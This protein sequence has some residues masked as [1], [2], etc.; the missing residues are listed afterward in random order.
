MT[1]NPASL[2]VK[3]VSATLP[4]AAAK[5]LTTL[6]LKA[7]SE[8]EV[9]DFLKGPSVHNVVMSG[10]IRDNGIESELHRG[11][12]YGCRD[13][14]GSL[15]GVAL[16][17]HGMFIQAHGNAAIREFARVAQGLGNAHMIMA[18]PKTIEEFWKSYSWGGQPL[19]RL[20]REL[21]FSLNQS[22]A[23]LEP[24]STLRPA[25]IG[26][27]PQ[28]LPV[29][30]AMAYEE[31]GIDP[32]LADPSGFRRRCLRR[33]EQG[34]VWVWIE[35]GKLIFKIDIIAD[36]P[37]AI[38]LEGV[39]V[40]PDARRKGHGSRC[41]SELCRRLMQRTKSISVLVNHKRHAAQRF[42]Q[43]IGFISSGLYDTIYLQI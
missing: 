13:D 25:T 34:R 27:L 16:I 36:T 10:F 37:D 4:F 24:V 23:N 38:Y 33:I 20:C 7:E 21:S 5:S 29:H 17:G 32:S 12:F 26:D 43:I 8:A 41:V 3:T 9:L 14:A 6:P 19:R 40:C 30:A 35:R 1:P 18:D 39:Y 28:V 22:P 2:N 11:R 42:F 15:E 31:S